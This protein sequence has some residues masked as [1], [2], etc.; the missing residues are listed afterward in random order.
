MTGFRSCFATTLAGAAVWLSCASPAHGGDLVLTD[1]EPSQLTSEYGPVK[2][3]SLQTP[4]L[5]LVDPH[6]L[7]FHSPGSMVH[8]R[9]AESVWI[10]AYETEIQDANGQPPAANLLCHTFFGTAHVEQLKG[11]DGKAI[12]QEMKGLFSDAFTRSVR[13]PDGFGIHLTAGDQME[14]MPMFN[15]RTDDDARVAMRATIHFIREADLH[16]PLQPVYS[17]LQSVSMPHLFYVRPGRH[18]QQATFDLPFNG[19][20]RLIG[21]HI[22]PYAKSVSLFN[23]TRGESVWNGMAR[24]DSSGRTVG[25]ALYSDTRGYPVHAGDVFKVSSVYD[26][27]NSFPID[28]MAGVFLVYTKD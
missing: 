24:E 2:R 26:N 21:A 23:T 20:I 3:A 16:K 22:H 12:S 8:F 9:F 28:A 1:F 5:A 14:W 27:P 25:M 7:A 13:L 17:V 6:M 4:G 18:E 15:N 10:I 19:T 11:P